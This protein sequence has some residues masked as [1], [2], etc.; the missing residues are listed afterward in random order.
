MVPGEARGAEPEGQATP[1]KYYR[2][3]SHTGTLEKRDPTV[4][5][6]TCIY[7]YNVQKLCHCTCFSIC[8]VEFVLEKCPICCFSTGSVQCNELV[9][10]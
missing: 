7:I 3:F 9:V 6:G 8:G 5:T 4:R 1:T 2:V 10:S